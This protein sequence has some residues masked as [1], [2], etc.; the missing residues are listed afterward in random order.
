MLSELGARMGKMFQISMEFP[1]QHGNLNMATDDIN[2]KPLGYHGIL[3]TEDM[4]MG[5][6]GPTRSMNSSSMLLGRKWASMATENE[7]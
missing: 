5:P 1:W 2:H 6:T 4:A 3:G 7:L